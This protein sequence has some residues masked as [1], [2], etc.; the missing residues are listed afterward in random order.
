[1]EVYLVV[2][3][4]KFDSEEFNDVH[5]YDAFYKAQNAFDDIIDGWLVEDLSNV[6]KPNSRRTEFGAENYYGVYHKSDDEAY[7]YIEERDNAANHI[8]VRIAHYE[9]K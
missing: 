9:I 8:S 4:V 7:F 3:K 5:I 6:G 1:M 2:Y